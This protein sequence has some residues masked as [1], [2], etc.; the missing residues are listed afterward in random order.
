VTV[1]KR[2]SS[3]VTKRFPLR[4]LRTSFPEQSAV[5]TPLRKCRIKQMEPAVTAAEFTQVVRIHSG[6]RRARNEADFAPCRTICRSSLGP[7]PCDP[8]PSCSSRE[9]RR[10]DRSRIANARV[11]SPPRWPVRAGSGGSSGSDAERSGLRAAPAIDVQENRVSFRLPSHWRSTA[12]GTRGSGF[13]GSQAKPNR[14]FGNLK[15]NNSDAEPACRDRCAGNP[16]PLLLQNNG[17]PPNW[18]RHL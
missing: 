2:I 1:G 7:Y 12:S 16:F 15:I 17:P 5:R 9:K 4:C 18:W 10:P 6:R 13:H 8:S 14:N 11:R 3:N